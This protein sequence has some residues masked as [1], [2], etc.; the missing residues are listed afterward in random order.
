MNEGKTEVRE[1]E[2]EREGKR[3]NCK[4]IDREKDREERERRVYREN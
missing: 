1:R 4:E 3:G 2:D